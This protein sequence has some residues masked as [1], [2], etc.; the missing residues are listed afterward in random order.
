MTIFFVSDC[1]NDKNIQKSYYNKLNILVDLVILVF[2]IYTFIIHSCA[3]QLQLCYESA[4]VCSIFIK[5]IQ[6]V[7][8][9]RFSTTDLQVLIIIKLWND[10]SS[11]K[12]NTLTNIQYKHLSVTHLPLYSEHWLHWRYKKKIM[13][14][15]RM[16]LLILNLLIKILLTF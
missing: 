4:H 12:A 11:C 7:Y 8:L 5:L 13:H 6:V 3:H 9:T 15:L 2:I 1:N 14:K 10:P 16:F